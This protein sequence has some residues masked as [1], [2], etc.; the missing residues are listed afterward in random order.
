VKVYLQI[1]IMGKKANQN[2]ILGKPTSMS[3]PYQGKKQMVR[4]ASDGE[5][6]AQAL[7]KPALPTRLEVQRSVVLVRRSAIGQLHSSS[8]RGR[9]AHQ[10]VDR[11]KQTHDEMN[12]KNGRNL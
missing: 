3:A 10:F 8:I 9:A 4:E 2:F 7:L 11:E 1:V 6:L 5:P 12:Q